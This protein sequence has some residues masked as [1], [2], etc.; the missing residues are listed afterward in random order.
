MTLTSRRKKR[1]TSNLE[2]RTFIILL[3]ILIFCKYDIILAGKT[4]YID[5][6]GRKVSLPACPRRVVSFAPSVTEIVHAIGCGHLLVGVS[7]FSDFPPAAARLPKVGSYI[8]LNLEKIVSLRPDMCIAIKDGNPID[9]IKRLE[10]LDI[11]VYVVDPVNIATLIEAISGIG[12]VLN[13]QKQAEDVVSK[14]KQTVLHIQN[15]LKDVESR[16]RVLYQLS[17]DPLIT[18]GRDTMID[19]IIEIA[20]GDNVANH[21]TGYPRMNM[22]KIFSLSPDVIIIPSMAGSSYAREMKKMWQ[23]W[24]TV[25]GVKNNRIFIVDSSLFD[26]PGPRIV[27][28]LEK[29]AS[30]LHPELFH[31]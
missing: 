26:R 10:A 27:Q 13:S 16:P 15:R 31:Q 14:I 22:E 24:P 6:T 29:M 9:I 12:K 20:G 5:Q 18:I 11:P 23:K 19:E 3:F 30:I 1:R 21:L 8:S 17:F 25:N 4:I 2:R 7:N 28:A